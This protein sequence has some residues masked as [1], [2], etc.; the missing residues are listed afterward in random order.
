MDAGKRRFHK[1]LVNGR[2]TPPG[3][4]A[5]ISARDTMKQSHANATARDFD[6]VVAD[7]TDCLS[8][9]LLSAA[10]CMLREE[11]K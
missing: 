5:V 2:A 3:P 6:E 4:A 7:L 8:E 10:Y 1:M 11:P 9:L